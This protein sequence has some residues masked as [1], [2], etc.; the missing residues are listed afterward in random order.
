MTAK[1]QAIYQAFR[2]IGY[3]TTASCP[4]VYTRGTTY[5]LL[6][7]VGSTFHIYDLE[8]LRLLFVGP[9]FD[10]T[11]TGMASVDDLTIV[12]VGSDIVT[13]QRAKETC[14]VSLPHESAVTFMT[15]L[16]D[17]LLTLCADNTLR[18]WRASASDLELV[19]EL[20]FA[21][22]FTATSLLHPSTYMN[23]VLVASREGVLQLWNIKAKKLVYAFASVGS[24][25]TVLS[26]SPVVDIIAIGLL[27]GSII[28]YN[29]KQ[30]QR[31]F[32]FTQ[33]GKV[34]A[35]SFRT[36][37]HQVMA[38][39]NATGDVALWNLET[40]R[41]SY[42]MKGAHDGSTSLA[43]F[44]TGQ[45]L[46]ITSGADNAVKTWIFDTLEI[47]PRLLRSRSGHHLPP[48]HIRFYGSEGYTIL[49]AG[50]DRSLR[51]FSIIRDSRNVEL[52]QGSMAKKLK[53][54]RNVTTIDELKL[55]VMTKFAAS[56][57]KEKEWDNIVSCHLNDHAARTW[58]YARK[59]I[60]NYQLPSLD[61]STITAVAISHCGNFS[62][63]GS[64]KG[65]MYK[66]NL[67]SG[68]HRQTFAK[69][70]SKSIIDICTDTLNRTV[71]SA[72]I[73]NKIIIWDFE[74]ATILQTIA[75][76][77]SISCMSLHKSSNLLAIACDDLCVRVMDVETFKIVR[78]YSG[79]RNR[80]TDLTFAPDGRWVVTSSLDG[81]IRT[82]D[83]VSGSMI[84]V[85]KV[86]AIAT[87]VAFSPTGDFLATAH[88]DKVGIFLWSNRAQYENLSLHAIDP[89]LEDVN[90]T[91]LPSTA[92]VNDDG[93]EQND[94]DD[95]EDE[96]LQQQ[97]DVNKENMWTAD[98]M[99]S[100]SS[101]V[102]SRWEILLKL[103][104][105]KKRNKP[106][107]APKAPERAPFFLPTLPGSQPKFAA[108][109]EALSSVADTSRVLNFTTFDSESDFWKTLRSC[110][111]SN[112]YTKFYNLVKAASPTS[113][114]LELR[115]MNTL[116]QGQSMLRFL[117]ALSVWIE[118][119]RDFEVVETL[120]H[121]FLRLH[122]DVILRQEAN[123]TEV[124]DAITRLLQRHKAEW[125]RLESRFQAATFLSDWSR[126]L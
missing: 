1:H 104:S 51:L 82:W 73:D 40:R 7:S 49:S 70:H 52:S 4:V 106:K 126:G 117:G 32:E 115:T 62:F 37:E 15:M 92:Q 108:P 3:I 5:Y 71:I 45:P 105:I 77:A 31:L 123:N 102:Q 97:T 116:D 103:D 57:A 64:S 88:A 27:N 72:S 124:K 50:R 87:S 61:D 63:L 47:Q 84:D 99:V 11:I 33:D 112:E 110:N 46:M 68:E 86:D 93:E 43:F 74:K 122:S 81:T 19:S 34:T 8:K 125:Q 28:L 18:V 35:I 26:Q 12:S 58:S 96:I 75:M 95:G 109:T 36:D 41:L 17:L 78:E 9:R 114:D 80:I 100:F 67:Q 90:V 85:L 56:S 76:D 22:N 66:Y 6:T 16:G 83:V 13:C 44:L 38:T 107:E 60:G 10:G 54:N 113:L 69:G 48:T 39:S 98:G 2:A 29:I 121:V 89:E 65:C 30:D 91:S 53:A 14:R 23:K 21:A 59:A 20:E 118:T 119:R 42:N 101:A 79:H 94:D 25:I 111:D 55:P 24:P 120:L